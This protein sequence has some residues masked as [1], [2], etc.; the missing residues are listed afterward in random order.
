[1]VG[2]TADQP[3]IKLER[4]DEIPWGEGLFCFQMSPGILGYLFF[5]YGNLFREAG[6]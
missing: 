5:L 3:R 6:A 2:L 4:E 1:M